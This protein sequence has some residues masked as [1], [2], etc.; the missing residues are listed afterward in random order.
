MSHVTGFQ[1]HLKNIGTTDTE[2]LMHNDQDALALENQLVESGDLLP[3]A[4]HF[5]V[6]CEKDAN[7]NLI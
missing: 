5:I 7:N 6:C 1:E 3:L 4:R 2:K